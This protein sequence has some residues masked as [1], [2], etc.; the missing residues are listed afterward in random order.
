MPKRYY[1]RLA[2]SQQQ[3]DQ[4]IGVVR[5]DVS[6][7]MNARQW[8]S[9]IGETQASLL[10][11][12]DLSIPGAVTRRPGYDMIADDISNNPVTGL[13][14]FEPIGADFFLYMKE[15]A[16]L[17]RWNGVSA[18][19]SSAV[20]SS[21]TS[22]NEY[23]MKPAF[24]TGEGTVLMLADG[25]GNMLRMNTAETFQDLGNTNDSPPITKV[26]TFHGTRLWCLKDELLYFSDAAPSDYSVGFD[27]TT[28]AFRISVGD[29]QAIISTRDLG[30]IIGGTKGIW[31]L[32]PSIVPDPVS[33]KPEP[34]LPDIGVAAGDTFV[35][36]A[37]D[38]VFLSYD[39]VYAVK[40]TIQDKLQLGESKPISWILGDEEIGMINWAQISKAKAVYFDGKYFLS[41]PSTGSSV[42]NRI[43]VY[44]VATQGWAVIPSVSIGRWTKWKDPVSG[45]EKLYGGDPSDGKV[46]QF[47][48]GTDDNGSV[49]NYTE[50]DR[51]ENIGYA[52]L[53]KVGGELV[54]KAKA[55]GD[56]DLNVYAAFD[57]DS[58]FT[59][60]GTMN[61]TG[62]GV[63]FPTSFPVV[64]ARQGYA[65]KKFHLDRNG[66]WYE[67]MVKITCTEA[68]AGSEDFVIYE[69]QIYTH[70]E[71]YHAEDSVQ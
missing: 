21:L 69:R 34:L 5:K 17:R 55:V 13:I 62:S 54:I 52:H 71:E 31:A 64:F 45:K 41:F 6:G 10:Y 22:G 26:F 70:L 24:E 35:Q 27:R 18:G 53:R 4:F 33:D 47:W 25:S 39:G 11:N 42:N 23:T 59:L 38:Y 15:G 46:Y 68:P 29:E 1:Q 37:D 28:Q 40:R 36:V 9:D 57:N 32:D 66:P 51:A 60:L 3:D 12:A 16:N 2:A 43:W 67:M 14:G 58:E 65:F 44:F 50:V 56:V 20:Y 61:L 49:I 7:G 30:L 8:P 19:W 63:T 48:T